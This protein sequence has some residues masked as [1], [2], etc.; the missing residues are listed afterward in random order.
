[1]IVKSAIKEENDWA[2]NN[3]PTFT[4]SILP[5]FATQYQLKIYHTPIY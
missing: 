1:M 4:P 3:L 5:K 2:L